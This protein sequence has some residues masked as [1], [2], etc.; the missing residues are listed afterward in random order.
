MI[1]KIRTYVDMPPLWLVAF[2]LL[3]WSFK[4]IWPEARVDSE[5]LDLLGGLLVGGGVL[6]A[7]LAVDEMRRSTTTAMPHRTASTL[8]QG[9]VF[10]WSRNPIYLGDLLIYLG[11][12]LF[13]GAAICAP[14]ALALA[15]ILTDRF[16]EPEEQRLT[17][18]FGQAFEDYRNRTRRWL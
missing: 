11:F 2:L 12:C 10:R 8:V 16:I 4:R 14:L 13:W 1:Q 15:W 7:L 6:L 17:E 5:V 18:A 3:P 9:G